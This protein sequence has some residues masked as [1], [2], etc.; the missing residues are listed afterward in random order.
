MAY[1]IGSILVVI[2]LIIMGLILRKRIYDEVD[3]LESWKMDIMNRNVTTEL[4][5]VKSLNL[6]GE[7][8]ENF[9]GWKEQWDYILT[10]ELPDIEEYLLDA[11][12]AADRF[13]I[14]TAKKNLQTV[15]K[16]LQ[17]IE[18]SI[19][20]MFTELD[21][22]LDS[23]QNSRQQMEELQ[24]QIKELRKNLLQN[25]H[26]F[27]KAEI[28]FEVE[29]DELEKQLGTYF[30][31]TDEG[32][33]FEAQRLVEKLKDELAL[34]EEQINDF[35]VTYKKCR[36]DLPMQ[37]DDLI[38][39][40]KTMKEDGYRVEH[41]GFEKELQQFHEK[42]VHSVTLLEEA[43]LTEVHEII[44]PIEDRI[45]EM[46]QLLE[47]EAFAKSYN[48]KQLP[49]YRKLLHDVAIDFRD[50]K[51]EVEQLQETYYLDNSDVETQADLEKKIIELNQRLEQMETDLEQEQVTNITIS[52]NLESCN[53]SLIE[54]QEAHQNF[55]QRL[56]TIR[57]DEID[58][59]EKVHEIR[60]RLFDT[61]RRL[62]KSNIP[63]VPSYIWDMLQ[64][65]SAKIRLVVEQLETHPL[66]MNEVQKS[67]KTADEAVENMIEQTELVLEN[68]RLVE[69]VI[70]YANRY[71][72]QD[73]ILAARLAEAENLF[74]NFEY[75]Q[76]L[77]EAAQALESV[78]PGALKRLED[79]NLVPS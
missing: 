51:D 27:G 25:R 33:Y 31:L 47:R 60:K 28:R 11:E 6:S 76:A 61:N 16:T 29:L 57:K 59:K 5:K 44:Q 65:A 15:E 45:A 74:R 30:E 14:S 38:K 77:E 55:K 36:Q 46:Y 40:I 68:A 3:R 1:V 32:N 23:E 73:A 54:L 34:V 75:E 56:Q 21:N 52:E 8:Q 12:E 22:L 69:L 49:A 64:Q 70:Q 37:I 62:Q 53:Q 63:G 17:S 19:D 58:A 24:P 72:S 18:K 66:D 9:E 26:Q 50:T 20:Q 7:T 10:T 13:R 4:S 2:V 79:L 41:L 48:E 42:V 67:L 78:E 35:P 43:K 71:R 39:G